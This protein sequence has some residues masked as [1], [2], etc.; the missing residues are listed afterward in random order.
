MRIFEVGD[1]IRQQTNEL[2]PGLEISSAT[3]DE[4]LWL[5]QNLRAKRS[6]CL[7]PIKTRFVLRRGI[8]RVVGFPF[9]G[10]NGIRPPAAVAEITVGL[11]T[12]L[13]FSGARD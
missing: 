4:I 3:A 12:H 7:N 9:A 11:K 2:R 6:S 8:E 10:A 1:I 13:A 5:I